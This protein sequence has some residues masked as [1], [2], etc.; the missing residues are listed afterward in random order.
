MA[1]KHGT[2]ESLKSARKHAIIKEIQT[3][4]NV[5]LDLGHA[6][7]DAVRAAGPQCAGALFWEPRLVRPVFDNSARLASR[8]YVGAPQ[9][10]RSPETDGMAR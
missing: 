5:A 7:V 1:R 10:E 4:W 6:A 2:G 9:G 3:D 8:Q